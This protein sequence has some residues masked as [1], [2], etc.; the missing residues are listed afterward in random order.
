MKVS[1]AVQI[2][3]NS[4]AAGMETMFEN[5][6]PRHLSTAKFVKNINDIFDLLNRTVVTLENKQ[7]IIEAIEEKIAWILTWKLYKKGTNITK[8]SKPP[9]VRGLVFTLKSFIKLINTIV[10]NDEVKLRLR[11]CNQDCIENLFGQ[12][13]AKGGLNNN[14]DSL[15]FI[16]NLR[17]L[18][19]AKSLAKSNGNCEADNMDTALKSL[20][21]NDAKRRLS[22][23]EEEIDTED[24]DIF[25]QPMRSSEKVTLAQRELVSIS[26]AN[27]INKEITE[28]EREV[29]HYAT[30][31]L[32]RKHLD[33]EFCKSLLSTE[34]HHSK[35]IQRKQ[36]NNFQVTF[37][38][39]FAT[40]FIEHLEEIF[41]CT[42]SKKHSLNSPIFGR[43]I[44]Q[45]RQPMVL[46]CHPQVFHTISKKYITLRICHHLIHINKIL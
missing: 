11:N 22:E 46:S 45:I 30:G 10:I 27:T 26:E 21:T 36:S 9:C 6:S 4:V 43:I 8:A 5:L 14:P 32:V 17:A 18:A 13:R 2:F 3:S 1:F 42:L 35:F 15:Q 39:K 19:F 23:L 34:E 33:C 38:S 44:H 41:R 29:L 28:E 37:P 20:N 16:G 25:E 12:L 40:N 31:A 24:A 7:K